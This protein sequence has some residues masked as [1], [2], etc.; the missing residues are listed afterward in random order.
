MCR[1]SESFGNIRPDTQC[2]NTSRSRVVRLPDLYCSEQPWG[3]PHNATLKYWIRLLLAVPSGATCADSSPLRAASKLLAAKVASRLA[4]HRCLK[5]A[6]HGF[7]EEP[8]CATA[9]SFPG[10]PTPKLL[11]AWGKLEAMATPKE[12]DPDTTRET[13]NE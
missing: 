13:T 8:T 11:R 4:V 5:L 10:R 6:Q 2:L 9:A 3:M 1:P 7:I 12:E